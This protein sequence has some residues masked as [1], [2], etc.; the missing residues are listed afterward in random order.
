MDIASVPTNG[1]ALAANQQMVK[2]FIDATKDGRLRVR[3]Q[4]DTDQSEPV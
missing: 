4:G 1:E 3:V 2:Q